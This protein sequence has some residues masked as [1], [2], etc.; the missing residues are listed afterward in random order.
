M[1]LYLVYQN[2]LANVFHNK[3]DGIETRILQ[4]SFRVCELFC[5]GAKYA[6]AEIQIFHCDK[7]GDIAGENWNKG[8]GPTFA[9]NKRAEWFVNLAKA[10]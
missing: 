6:G 4:D 5:R 2:G 10:R 3:G 7:A 9:G 1:T 8:S